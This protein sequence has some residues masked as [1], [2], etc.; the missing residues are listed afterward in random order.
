M[1]R[2]CAFFRFQP[3]VSEAEIDQ[4]LGGFVGL[5]DEVDGM[6]EVIVGPNV[7]SEG[8]S[9]GFDHGIVMDFV[10]VDAVAAYLVHPAHLAHAAKVVPRL[11]GGLEGAL[12]FD[13]EI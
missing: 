4:L 8:L 1:I 13:L 7:S 3:D 2:H 10:D 12:P 11:E 6:L 5:K 9:Q